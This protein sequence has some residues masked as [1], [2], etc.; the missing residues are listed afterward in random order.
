MGAAPLALLLFARES[1][2]LAVAGALVAVFTAGMAAG[3]PVPARAVDRWRQP[4]ILYGSALLSA[5]GY[6]VVALSGGRAGL[7]VAGAALA[8]LGPPPM[9]ACLRALWPDLVPP[10]AVHAAY[11]LD[12]AL[13]EVI[14]VAGPLVTPAAVAIGGPTA[15][16]LTAAL[17]QLAGVIAF[18]RVPAVRRWRGRPARRHWLG[19]LREHRLAVMV[20]GILIDRSRPTGRDGGPDDHEHSAAILDQAAA[21]LAPHGSLVLFT[22]TG[23]VGGRDPFQRAAAEPLTGT[24]L[25]WA[26]HEVDSDVFGEQLDGPAY[27]DTERIALVMLV[28][29]RGR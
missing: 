24:G 8:G 10:S 22:S 20:T 5:A 1:V 9:E 26:Y 15:G 29:T 14:F 21:H 6:V 28:A 18:V 27:A 19:P 7:I 12:V 23:I 25:A 16:L 2:S 13:Q 3:A 17:L 4:P 11:A